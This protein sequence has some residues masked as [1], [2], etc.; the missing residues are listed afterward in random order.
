MAVQHRTAL[1]SDFDGTVS[2]D[3]F[4]YYI[5]RQY[6]GEKSLEPWRAYME[7][8]KIGRASCRERVSTTV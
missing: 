5:S 6:L 7:G 4:F 8:K 3:D 2:D 1:V